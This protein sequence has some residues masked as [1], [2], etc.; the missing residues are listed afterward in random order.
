MAP[1]VVNSSAN[2]KQLFELQKAANAA[3]FI[4]FFYFPQFILTID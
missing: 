1:V 4:F 3:F 2:A